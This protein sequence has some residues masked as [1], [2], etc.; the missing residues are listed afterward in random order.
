MAKVGF[1]HLNPK[2]PTV[3]F[4]TDIWKV[5]GHLIT[6]SEI[7]YQYN[8]FCNDCINYSF[9]VHIQTGILL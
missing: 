7:K 5:F 9:R 6:G 8:S 4:H 1:S 2:L 3:L